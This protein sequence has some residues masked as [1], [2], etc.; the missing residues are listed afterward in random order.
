[1]HQEQQ[2]LQSTKRAKM[3]KSDM[4]KIKENIARLKKKLKPGQ[5]LNE[6]IQ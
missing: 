5:T 4:T 6:A 3:T 1:M 2:H